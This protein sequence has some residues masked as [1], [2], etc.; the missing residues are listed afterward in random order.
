MGQDIEISTSGTKVISPESW[1]QS[2]VE[3]ESRVGLRL[4]ALGMNKNFRTILRSR[5]R[6]RVIIHKVLN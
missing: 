5:A 3:S 2:L 6:S 1:T 4:G